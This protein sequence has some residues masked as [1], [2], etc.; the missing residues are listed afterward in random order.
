MMVMWLS[1]KEELNTETLVQF[2]SLQSSNFH[3]LIELVAW[4]V[5]L[6]KIFKN[7]FV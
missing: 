1:K 5:D 2:I 6:L 4:E 7:Y 3:S